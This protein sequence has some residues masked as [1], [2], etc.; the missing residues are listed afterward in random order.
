MEGVVLL[1]SKVDGLTDR[2]A[3]MEDKFEVFEKFLHWNGP[4]AMR[5]EGG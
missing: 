5:K 4:G 1:A 2:V 3:R